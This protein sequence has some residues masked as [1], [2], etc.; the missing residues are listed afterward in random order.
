MTETHAFFQM[1]L[2]GVRLIS[3][4]H[5]R[6]FS[7]DLYGRI[8]DERRIRYLAFVKRLSA[9]SRAV[10]RENTVAAVLASSHNKISE[11]RLFAVGALS[12]DD[13]AP[14]VRIAA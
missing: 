4:G 2:D 13:A 5:D 12:D 9:Q 3:V 11:H 7:D 14:C 1:F 8:D 10:L 6:L